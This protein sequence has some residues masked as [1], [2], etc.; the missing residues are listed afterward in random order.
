MIQ[1]GCQ[2]SL[3]RPAALNVGRDLKVGRKKRRPAIQ[4]FPKSS[5]KFCLSSDSS[6]C[7]GLRSILSLLVKAL[8]WSHFRRSY[9]S[10]LSEG[11]LLAIWPAS[12][13]A[14]SEGRSKDVVVSCLLKERQIEYGI[15]DS[16]Y[17]ER[18]E[19][20]LLF[21]RNRSQRTQVLNQITR[22]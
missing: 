3:G 21:W 2:Y 8:T 9:S 10:V 19:T 17:S 6:S 13:L 15:A 16:V 12:K 4:L 5:S 11:I 18:Y 7:F 20:G 14:H 22:F 1:A